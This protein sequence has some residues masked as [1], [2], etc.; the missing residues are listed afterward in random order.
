[1][2]KL[3]GFLIMTMSLSSIAVQAG[4]DMEMK[5]YIGSKDF[6]QLK[7]LAGTWE[8]SSKENGKEEKVSV[9]YSVTS[10]GSVVMEKLFTSTPNEMVSIYTDKNG[11]PSMVHY[12][13]IGNHPQ[14]DLVS[15]TEGNMLFDFSPQSDIDAKTEQHMHSLKIAFVDADHFTQSWTCF[16]K[17]AP[18]M[19]STF[20][21][22]R[23]KK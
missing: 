17:G 2:R 22:S 18:H 15:S 20:T 21:F 23:V 4:Q 8:G 1:M 13:A 11:K 6:K 16:E 9:E 10:N 3:I 5:P 19:T 14:M 7:T 12:C